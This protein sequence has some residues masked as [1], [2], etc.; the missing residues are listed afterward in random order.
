[1]IATVI[2]LLENLPQMTF[3]LKRLFLLTLAACVC[4]AAIVAYCDHIKQV[5]AER[6]AVWE[7]AE[8]EICSRMPGVQPDKDCMIRKSGNK[9]EIL[10]RPIGRATFSSGIFLEIDSSGNVLNFETGW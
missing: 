6:Q 7:I 3:S 8:L 1:M 10:T 4:V 5:E 2:R 9:W